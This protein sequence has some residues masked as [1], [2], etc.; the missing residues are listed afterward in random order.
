MFETGRIYA[1]IVS[2][3]ILVEKVDGRNIARVKSHIQPEN[4]IEYVK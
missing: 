2:I 4:I 1:L 3:I